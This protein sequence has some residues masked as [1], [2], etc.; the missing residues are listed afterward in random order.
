MGKSDPKP[1]SRVVTSRTRPISRVRTGCL[2]CRQRTK[3]CDEVKP[4]C[5]ACERNK[6]Q[7]EW[8]SSVVQLTGPLLPRLESHEFSAQEWRSLDADSPGGEE[9]YERPGFGQTD[10]A[11]PDRMELGNRVVCGSPGQQHENNSIVSSSLPLS[12]ATYSSISEESNDGSHRSEYGYSKNYSARVLLNSGESDLQS[13]LGRDSEDCMLSENEEGVS[14][15]ATIPAGEVARSFG[16]IN[17]HSSDITQSLFIPRTMSLLPEYGHDAFQLLGHY[18]SRTAESMSN[19]FTSSNP[20]LSQLIPLA[21]SSDV[22]LRLILTQSAA[23]RAVLHPTQIDN[24]ATGH[25]SKSVK[26]F[27]E[28][29][30]DHIWGTSVS[31][32]MLAVGALIMCFTEV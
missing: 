21:F 8:P 4:I 10:E 17:N 14:P 12:T 22:I 19:G 23:H 1:S 13:Q 11:S 26:L 2:R 32:L 15:S 24:V 16:D 3:K 27:R 29:I 30:N 25:Y 18:L 20:F 5:R 31:P 9:V 6:F 28:R 7:C